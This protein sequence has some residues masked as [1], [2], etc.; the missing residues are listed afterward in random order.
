MSVDVT[1]LMR[2]YQAPLGEAA[3]R[4]LSRVLAE[5]WD[6]LRG[7]RLLG[8][9]YATPYLSALG[10]DC[11]RTIAFMPPSQ[12]VVTWPEPSR[13]SSAL[14]DPTM[15]PLPEGSIDRVLVVHA[16]EMAPEPAEML[17][18]I[19][20]ILT[21]SGRALLV[22][23]NRRGLWT[24]IDTTPFGHGQ[25]FSRKQIRRLLQETQLEAEAWR[26]TL[27][28]PPLENGLVLR[29]AAAWERMGRRLALPFAGLHVVEAGKRLHRPIA[30][31]TR[32]GSKA[33]RPVFLPVPASRS[34][35]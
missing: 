8:I 33:P 11:E 9:G 25:P 23:P 19:A 15:L 4:Q 34:S 10:A 35:S 17:H 21:P 24:R 20:R 32:R 2:F 27:Y 29:S 13:S 6:G 30:V 16:I 26:E 22:F 18:E 28:M 5:S 7:L 14:A 31:R 1:D 12:G 3:R